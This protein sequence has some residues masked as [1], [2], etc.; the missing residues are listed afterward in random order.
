[1]KTAGIWVGMFVLW[2]ISFGLLVDMPVKNGVMSPA[3]GGLPT[4]ILIVVFVYLGI[5]LVKRSKRST[6]IPEGTDN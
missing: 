6:A 2:A 5:K 4:L 3:L 1:M